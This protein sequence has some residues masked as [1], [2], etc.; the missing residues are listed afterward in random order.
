MLIPS[1]LSLDKHVSVVSVKCFFHLRHL[2]WIH[3]MTSQ[4][5]DLCPYSSP[6]ESMTATIC[7]P[8]HQRQQWT[9]CSMN[10]A[11]QVTTNWSVTHPTPWSSLAVCHWLH[12]NTDC[13]ST[14][15]NIYKAGTAVFVW[16]LY[17]D[18][19][20]AAACGECWR[21]TCHQH[22]WHHDLY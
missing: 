10:A 6:R 7:W 5:P 9:S 13:T 22:V 1:D 18:N 16:S 3:W 15:T 20:Q 17:A 19:R 2:H 12:P 4:L 8:V 14:S 21:I 11:P